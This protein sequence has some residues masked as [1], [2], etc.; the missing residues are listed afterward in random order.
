MNY[1]RD[2]G[3]NQNYYIF[4]TVKQLDLPI[5]RKEQIARNCINCENTVT[6]HE[7]HC[8]S[9]CQ[10]KGRGHHGPFCSQNIVGNW[11]CV[12]MSDGE[13]YKLTL[14][15]DFTITHSEGWSLDDE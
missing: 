1:I 8:C 13:T 14:N 11:N 7:T 4:E 5:Y 10:I 6:W 9:V 3:K 15:K 2:Q 12:T